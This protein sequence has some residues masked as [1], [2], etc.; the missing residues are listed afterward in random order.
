MGAVEG[1]LILSACVV[2]GRGEGDGSAR[3]TMPAKP[4]RARTGE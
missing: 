4:R 3:L 1:G 2:E